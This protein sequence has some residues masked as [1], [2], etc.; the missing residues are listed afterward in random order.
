MVAHKTFRLGLQI[1]I[2][3]TIAQHTPEQTLDHAAALHH[4]TKYLKLCFV[5]IH[6]RFRHCSA[7]PG[8]HRR[9]KCP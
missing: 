8:I 3:C 4:I 5:S 9:W 6:F 1:I 2:M 7:G